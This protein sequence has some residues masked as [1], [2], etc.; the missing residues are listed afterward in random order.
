MARSRTSFAPGNQAARTHGLRAPEYR[1]NYRLNLLTAMR[2]LIQR[3]LGDGQPADEIL[4]DLLAAALADI[5][6]ADD[7]INVHGGPLSTKGQVA[8]ASHHRRSREHDALAL[9]DRLGMGPKA[10]TQ[11]LAG[12]VQSEGLASQLARARLK[13]AQ[14]VYQPENGSHAGGVEQGAVHG[15]PNTSSIAPGA[16]GGQGGASRG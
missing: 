1:E 15:G 13:Q 2:E 9:M 8:K 3:G 4:R 10:R 11:I 12:A 7:W 5:R 14:P 16:S 6:Q